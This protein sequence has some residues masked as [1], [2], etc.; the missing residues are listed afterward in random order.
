MS[1]VAD[2]QAFNV[3]NRSAVMLFRN[4]SRSVVLRWYDFCFEMD[5]PIV[6]R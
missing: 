6:L 3:F 4:S 1:A 2:F 5:L